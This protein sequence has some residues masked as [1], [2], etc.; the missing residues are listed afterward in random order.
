MSA[1]EQLLL[2]VTELI[3]QRPVRWADPDQFIGDFD[4]RER[5][6]EIFNADAAEQRELLR[7]MRPIQEELE[8]VAGGPVVTVFHTRAES[9]RLHQRFVSAHED[10]IAQRLMALAAATKPRT[11][12]K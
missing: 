8:A 12:S 5:T 7:R 6:L 9:V 11:G 3:D 1:R 10:A 2:R 4:G